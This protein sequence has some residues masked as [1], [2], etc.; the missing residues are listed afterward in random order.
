MNRKIS[1]LILVVA[2]L[3][4]YSPV[5]FSGFALDDTIQIVRLERL[6]HIGNVWYFLTSG[7]QSPTAGSGFL[8]FYY[9]P[10]L[11]MLYTVLYG[12]GQGSAFPFH[13]LQLTVFLGD[14]L[15][16]FTFFSLFFSSR[17][18]FVLGLTFLAHP[19]NQSAGAYIAEM[20]MTFFLFFG[21]LA[22][23][24]LGRNISGN[25][26]E[27]HEKGKIHEYREK[28]IVNF[29][30]AQSHLD[31]SRQLAVVVNF[32]LVSIFLLC[33]L[34]F[35]EAGVLFLPLSVWYGKMVG[36]V[37]L[38]VY[39]PFLFFVS[40][41]YLWLRSISY[42]NYF[43]TYIASYPMKLM[44]FERILFIPTLVFFYFKEIFTPGS[45]VPR[46]KDI[47][48]HPPSI[49]LVLGVHLAVLSSIFGYGLFLKKYKMKFFSLFLFFAFWFYLG[50]V[51]YVQIIPLDLTI[52][53]WWLS[54]A[55]LGALGMIGVVVTATPVR[56][57]QIRKVIAILYLVFL[58]ALAAQTVKQNLVLR[59]WQLHLAEP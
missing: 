7:L 15:L 23:I 8:T 35:V 47:V 29:F 22:L 25:N 6:H 45:A 9:R 39:L 48:H 41:F 20:N 36:K 54:F 38:R 21:L 50:F 26:R 30:S 2:V 14:V 32:T 49:L 34:L 18:A 33:S 40:A 3:L 11:F 27:T 56:D 58:L 4:V 44:L 1:V 24:L 52:A 55:L 57:R 13:L 16:V 37:R 51:L 19:I 10:L 53:R 17:T 31:L 46:V 12:L 28:F 42:Q 59:E 5:F 43:L